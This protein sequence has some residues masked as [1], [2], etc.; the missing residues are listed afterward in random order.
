MVNAS[1]LNFHFISRNNARIL[2]TSKVREFTEEFSVT[3]SLPRIIYDSRYSACS[4]IRQLITVKEDNM[5]QK[6]FVRDVYLNSSN[7]ASLN[8]VT[9]LFSMVV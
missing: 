7:E 5:L 2:S 1:A 6:S 9:I 8:A 4:N 3:K